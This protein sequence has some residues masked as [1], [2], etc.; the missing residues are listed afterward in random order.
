MP[1]FTPPIAESMGA[2]GVNL[3][4]AMATLMWLAERDAKSEAHGYADCL[5]IHPQSQ[6]WCRQGLQPGTHFAPTGC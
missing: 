2:E 6:V 3:R 4:S 1:P 5:S